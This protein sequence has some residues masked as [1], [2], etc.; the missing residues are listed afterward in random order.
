VQTAK[1]EGGGKS[2]GEHHEVWNSH[3]PWKPC[4]PVFLWQEVKR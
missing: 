3:R 4:K 2:T 1:I